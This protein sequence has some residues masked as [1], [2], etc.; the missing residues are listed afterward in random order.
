VQVLVDEMLEAR[1]SAK[2]PFEARARN[3]SG[4]AFGPK[5]IIF[6]HSN[7]FYEVGERVREHFQSQAN[8]EQRRLAVH[9]KRPG[10]SDW[11]FGVS[12]SEDR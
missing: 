3:M 12:P 11:I 5:E 9:V 6:A 10:E 7:D 4:V 2:V 8:E 1:G